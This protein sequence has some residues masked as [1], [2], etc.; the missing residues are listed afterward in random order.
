MKGHGSI[1]QTFEK[2]KEMTKNQ[3]SEP[4]TAAAMNPIEFFLNGLQG[5]LI[6]NMNNQKEQFKEKGKP[7]AAE[8]GDKN[9]K[10]PALNYFTS[11]RSGPAD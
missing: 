8:A 5:V 10:T 6:G 9:Q 3:V 2:G 11:D 1:I 7:I 4:T